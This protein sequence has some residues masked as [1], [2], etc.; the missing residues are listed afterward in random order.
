MNKSETKNVYQT[1]TMNVSAEK[2]P[3]S[4]PA[5]TKTSKETDMRVRG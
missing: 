1:L 2:K 3:K 4:E 5:V